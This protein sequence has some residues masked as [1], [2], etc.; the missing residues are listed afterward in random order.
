MLEV[1][2]KNEFAK[3]TVS[4]PLSML[5]IR[6]FGLRFSTLVS[7][8]FLMLIIG[9]CAS[10]PPPD[11]AATIESQKQ[12]KEFASLNQKI[13]Q[14][15]AASK[16][17]LGAQVY[18]LGT[19]DLLELTVFR[20]TELNRKVRVNANGQIMLPLLGTLSLGGLSVLEAES[21]IA[22]K[23]AADYLQ[24][25]QVSLFVQ[26]YRSQEITVMGAVD[27]PDV[28][29]VKQSRS[30]FEMLSLAGGLS[31]SAG[32][33]IRISTRQPNPSNGEIEQVDLVI[34]LNKLLAGA[35]RAANF[36]L[37]G[38]DSILVPEAGFVTVEGAVE[39]PGSYKMDGQTNVIKAVALAGGIPWTGKQ[40]RVKVIRSEEDELVVID[41]NLNKVRAQPNGD[42]ILQDGDIVSVSHSATKRAFAG[43][44]KTA[45]Q[46]LGY[47][48]N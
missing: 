1:M 39:K 10:A 13:A 24:N 14:S 15:A 46:I 33:L 16:Q 20:V 4:A 45:G 3:L 43:F 11:R 30:I 44:F 18:R 29:S 5:R 47:R 48:I 12:D 19:G 27:K 37:S 17:K 7:A 6:L 34:S 23:L 28:Y 35:G 26:E 8:V 38:G 36:R 25:P 31:T 42:I 2:V 41:V 9:G 21:L 32:D 40:S 22:E